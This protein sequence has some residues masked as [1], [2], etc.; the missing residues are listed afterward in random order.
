M[1]FTVKQT[2]NEPWIRCYLAI[3]NLMFKLFEILIKLSL[4][5]SINVKNNEPLN[6]AKIV[7]PLIKIVIEKYIAF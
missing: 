5:C 3:F 6:S 4:F 2:I 7:F 1:S